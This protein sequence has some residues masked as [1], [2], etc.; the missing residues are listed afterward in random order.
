[1]FLL[2][3]KKQ[4]LNCGGSSTAKPDALFS[5]VLASCV[6]PYRWCLLLFHLHAHTNTVINY[7][8]KCKHGVKSHLECP[9]ATKTAHVLHGF[10][11]VLLQ[12]CLPSQQSHM[13]KARLPTATVK[14]LAN[15]F[16]LLEMEKH[17][18]ILLASVLSPETIKVTVS[19]AASKRV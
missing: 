12:D 14:V 2:V 10:V 18:D 4:S 7:S 8:F 17:P 13:L 6:Q 1:M 3:T 5:A 15:R 9:L 16:F 19:S 11:L